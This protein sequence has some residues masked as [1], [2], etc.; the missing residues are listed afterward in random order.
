EPAHMEN[1]AGRPEFKE[2]LQGRVGSSSR[3]SRTVG[4]D[5]LYVA[6]PIPG[7]AVRLAYPLNA[8]AEANK[9]VRRTLFVASLLAILVALI[10]AAVAAQSITRRLQRIVTFSGQIA[11]GDLSA[12]IDEPSNDEIGK[13]ARSLDRTAKRLQESFL[14][15][16]ESRRELETL[17]NS[18][19]E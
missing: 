12:R 18:M 11:E 4:I 13:V 7:G 19:Q 9:K 16:E 1:H 15:V 8:I 17:L 3:E 14:A 5:F 6:A 2:A 10:I